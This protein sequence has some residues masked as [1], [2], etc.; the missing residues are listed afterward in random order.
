MI[1]LDAIRVLSSPLRYLRAK[2][3]TKPYWDW[4]IPTWLAAA[5]VW[6]Y[7]QFPAQLPLATEKGLF[8]SVNQLLQV[9]VGF[10]IAALAAV[11][12]L[13]SVSLDQAVEGDPVS[14]VQRGLS[15]PVVLNRR[16]L[17]SMMFAYLS[18]TSIAIYTL[19]V[20]AILGR[21]IFNDIVPIAAKES[22]KVSFLAFYTIALVQSVCITLVTLFYL[23][24]RMHRQTPTALPPESVV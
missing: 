17:I 16:R 4:V 6:T 15:E 5:V 8:A 2:S 13:N 21:D 22:I 23:G 3:K 24:D 14:I 9:L 12:S 10:Y 7:V 20:V 11:A 18:F 1:I 19:G